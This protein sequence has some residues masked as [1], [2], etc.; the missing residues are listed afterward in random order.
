MLRA[1]VVI[2]Y[3]NIHLTARDTFAPY[4]TPAHETLVHPVKFGEELIGRW[5]ELEPSK[6]AEL[7]TV[8][9]YRGAP[10]NRQQPDLYKA[11]QRQKS[12]WT[13]DRR[14]QLTYRTLRYSNKPN[15]PPR[16]K[17]VDVLVALNLVKLASS[18]DFDLVILAAH[19]TDLEPALEMA[20]A[21][22]SATI[23]I[24]GWHGCKKLAPGLGLRYLGLDGAT[25]VRTRDRRDYFA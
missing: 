15:V 20:V 17:G 1:A 16:E 12:E 19:D 23:A 13:R 4:G 2:D 3:Q 22:G 5:N 10:S 6:P 11:T 7:I 25:F 21:D 14:L 8:A 24:G 9:A 18:P